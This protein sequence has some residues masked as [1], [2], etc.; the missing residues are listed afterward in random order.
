MPVYKTSREEIIKKSFKVFL[1]KGYYHTSISDLSKACEIEK[2][3]FYYYFKD[4][5]DIMISVL[6]FGKEWAIKNMFVNA[7]N[8]Q[9]S[10]SERMK[11]MLEVFKSIYLKDYNGCIFSNTA[12][13]TSNNDDDFAQVIKEYFDSWKK[14]LIAIYIEKFNSPE[15]EQRATRFFNELN[16]AVMMMKLYKDIS[17]LD[18]F[19]NNH[20]NEI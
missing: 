7:Y 5:K 1:S 2:A 10:P 19:I 9:I 14:A 17:Y 20:I 13:E 4:K 15:S 16:G 6:F 3:H 8:K 11:K 18:G 12:L